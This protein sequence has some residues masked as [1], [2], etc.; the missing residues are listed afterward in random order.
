MSRGFETR[1]TLRALIVAAALVFAAQPAAGAAD[2]DEPR[3]STTRQIPDG[4]RD[5]NMSAARVDEFAPLETEGERGKTSAAASGKAGSGTTAAQGTANDFWFHTAD[6]IL[7]NDDDDDGY[8]HGIDLLFDADTY[9][10]AVDVYAVGFLS[11]EGGP[12]NEYMVTD[13]FT[14]FGATSDDEYVV[15]TEL[16]SGYRTGEYDLLIELY[17]AVDGAFLAS[18]GPADTSELAF[19]PLEDFDRDDPSFD[20]VVVVE[21]GGGSVGGIAVAAL[22][23]ILLLRLVSVRRTRPAGRRRG[24]CA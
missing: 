20:N 4:G 11:Y 14:I 12:W 15:V 9:F 3:R 13:T 5:G 6:V 24:P 16:T 1:S 19:L 21:R 18:F 23:S 17:D 2:A 7:F 10:D 8:F 22:L